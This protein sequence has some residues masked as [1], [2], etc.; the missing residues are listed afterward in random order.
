[1][2]IAVI[3]TGTHTYAVALTNPTAQLMN[4]QIYR[5]CSLD[6]GMGKER[7]LKGQGWNC[8]AGAQ[9]S[10]PANCLLVALVVHHAGEDACAPSTALT[11][12]NGQARLL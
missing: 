3:R 10:S 2:S 6:E 12:T 5:T 1:M 8:C 11:M 9:A 7:E 4:D